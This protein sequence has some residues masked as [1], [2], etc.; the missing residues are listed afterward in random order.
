MNDS[1]GNEKVARQ[2]MQIIAEKRDSKALRAWLSTGELI[3]T[4][5]DSAQAYARL[6]IESQGVDDD[7]ILT[8]FNLAREDTPSQEPELRRALTAIAKERNSS[9]LS[10][11]LQLQ[12]SPEGH[13]ASQWPVGLE[14]IGNTCYLNSL[15]QFYYTVK[16]LR[17][18]VLH[19]DLH[20]TE[21]DAATLER[22][23]VG[24]RKVT[25]REVQ[26]AQSC[27]QQHVS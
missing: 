20:K 15:L 10:N 26:R 22:K 19:F 4:E 9:L 1:A 17:D 27:K 25:K 24:S 12:V 14:N 3:E 7:F 8:V 5:M 11:A 13:D 18:L 6:N 23:H 2:C 21:M 16:P